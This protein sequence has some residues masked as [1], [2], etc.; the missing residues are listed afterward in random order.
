MPNEGNHTLG[1]VLVIL[2]AVLCTLSV[3]VRLV[4]R[5]SM[6][7]IDIEGAFVACALVYSLLLSC[8]SAKLTACKGLLRWRGLCCLRRLL[9]HQWNLQMKHLSRVQYVSKNLQILNICK[10]RNH[11]TKSCKFTSA[12][13]SMA[14]SSCVSKSPY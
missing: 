11:L 12:P 14:S 10:G 4:S 8:S 13:S 7:E 6:K 1:Y 9:F 3:A 2:S 5:Y